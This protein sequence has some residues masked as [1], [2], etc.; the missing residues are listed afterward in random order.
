MPK[1]NYKSLS[2]KKILF[3]SFFFLQVLSYSQDKN[4]GGTPVSGIKTIKREASD[5]MISKATSN[6]TANTIL[7]P[8]APT[9]GSPEV[10]ITEGQ[11]DV[12]LSGAATY[13]IPIA[14]PPGINGVVPQISITYSSQ[15]GS[16][17]V[18]FG[19]N[20]S[21]ISGISRIR[22]A[23]PLNISATRTM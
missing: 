8:S 15:S 13:T 3:I 21:G 7:A 22:W 5:M 9:G 4:L 1:I 19:W 6:T 23:A 11:L 10:G 17:N 18:G 16:G 12:S 20:V 2:M 14:V